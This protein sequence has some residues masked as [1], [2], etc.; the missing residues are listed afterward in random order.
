M[1]W[2][3]LLYVG[4]TCGLLSNLKPAYECQNVGRHSWLPQ[5][6]SPSEEDPC[7]I[8]IQFTIFFYF[9]LRIGIEWPIQ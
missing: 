6:L 1:V 5:K 4:T 8:I 7:L 9:F 2:I 3:R